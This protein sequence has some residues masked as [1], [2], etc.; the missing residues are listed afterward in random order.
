M[1]TTVLPTEE[2]QLAVADSEG[3]DLS[4]EQKAEWFGV[5]LEGKK[6]VWYVIKR[7][8]IRANCWIMWP[9]IM[10]ATFVAFFIYIF[11]VKDANAVES[12]AP[13]CVIIMFS[14]FF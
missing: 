1:N 13:C 3:S 4:I 14:T 8:R 10:T 2:E 12:V 11:Q 6:D 9:I 7:Y 5:S